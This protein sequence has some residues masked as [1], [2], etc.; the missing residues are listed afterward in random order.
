MAEELKFAVK[1]RASTRRPVFR[2][3]C[4]PCL[5]NQGLSYSTPGIFVP[6]HL[7]GGPNSCTHAH[8]LGLPIDHLPP[9][10]MST[11]SSP[12]PQTKICNHHL[13]QHHNNLGPNGMN[14]PS[15]FNFTECH[16]P[17]INTHLYLNRSKSVGA[18]L[19]NDEYPTREHYRRHEYNLENDSCN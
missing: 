17:S 10:V 4:S 14:L 2:R 3:R 8:P 9:I 13:H 5:A 18:P 11:S 15:S 12:S 1:C 6:G 7:G 19:M 16:S